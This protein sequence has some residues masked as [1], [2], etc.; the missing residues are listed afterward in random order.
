MH[1]MQK[2][3]GRIWEGKECLLRA[4]SALCIALPAE[5]DSTK[6]MSLYWCSPPLMHYLLYLLAIDPEKDKDKCNLNHIMASQGSWES[7]L[8]TDSQ[9]LRQIFVA[10]NAYK[11]CQ[12]SSRQHIVYSI[13]VHGDDQMSIQ[14]Q[15]TSLVHYKCHL[16][17]SFS[18]FGCSCNRW[19]EQYFCMIV[20]ERLKVLCCRFVEYFHTCSTMNKRLQS[21]GI[22]MVLLSSQQ[23][24]KLQ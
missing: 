5:L 4:I 13:L 1:C 16:L 7:I 22:S 11:C 6:G 23:R 15:S 24:P 17:N 12:R 9:T 10:N 19:S 8:G 14:V 3:Q 21:I 20:V 18:Q 2:L